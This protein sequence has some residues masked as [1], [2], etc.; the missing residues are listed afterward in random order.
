MA[1]SSKSREI[2]KT[3]LDIKAIF[4][5]PDDMFTWASGIKSPIYCDNRIT[6]SYPTA[7]NLIKSAFVEL[8][9]NKYPNA[10]Y[11]AGVATAGIPHAALI[12]DSLNLPMVYVRASSKDH[13]RSNQIEGSIPAGAKA[14]VIEDLISTGGSSISAA[15]ALQDSGIEVL[16]MVAIFTY[17]LKKA[18]ANFQEANIQCDALSDYKILIET[19]LENK[20]ITKDQIKILEDWQANL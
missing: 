15:K 2:A 12:A 14:I 8:I 18:Q 9:K 6:L 11:V 17:G 13:G 1:V 7:R 4:L 20:Q 3:L 10:E 19:A 5:R 16:G